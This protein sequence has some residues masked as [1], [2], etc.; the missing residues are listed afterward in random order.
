MK[1]KVLLFVPPAT[2]YLVEA[3]SKELQDFYYRNLVTKLFKGRYVRFLDLF[4]D[5]RFDE[6]DF[7]DFEHLNHGGAEKLTRIIGK[8]ILNWS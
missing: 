3:S 2:R 8:V 6:N 5:E 7:C 4:D 1:I